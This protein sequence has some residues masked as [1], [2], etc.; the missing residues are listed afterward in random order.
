MFKVKNLNY[1]WYVYLGRG[2][3]GGIEGGY[4]LVIWQINLDIFTE[5]KAIGFKFT[6]WEQNDL[7]SEHNNFM[8]YIWVK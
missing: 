4:N 2:G 3:G 7:K 5:L 6:D 1:Y 8:G